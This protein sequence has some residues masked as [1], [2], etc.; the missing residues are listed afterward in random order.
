MALAGGGMANWEEAALVVHPLILTAIH[1]PQAAGQSEL[2]T[3]ALIWGVARALRE[4]S[5]DTLDLFLHDMADGTSIGDTG[6][7]SQ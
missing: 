7:L 3:L 5:P 6:L 2:S 1:G 4:T